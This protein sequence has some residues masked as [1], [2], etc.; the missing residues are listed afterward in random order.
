ML[1]DRFLG[2]S[3][4]HPRLRVV[5]VGA[6]VLLASVLYG[7]LNVIRLITLIAC[8]LGSPPGV[9]MEVSCIQQH[10][11]AE[12][13]IHHHLV[14]ATSFTK[15]LLLLGSDEVQAAH[16]DELLLARD[17]VGPALALDKVQGRLVVLLEVGEQVAHV[18]DVNVLVVAALAA[19]AVEG[20]VELGGEAEGAA[21]LEVFA[22]ADESE[23]RVELKVGPAAAAA[24]ALV[25]RH[26]CL[27]VLRAAQ[28]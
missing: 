15:P 8:D 27:A 12:A 28:T 16:E 20:L 4:Q 17:D 22:L 23:D 21:L 25:G 6:A 14:T 3:G 2:I 1:L 26:I 9:H 24:L 5:R 11:V 13:S 10:L 19:A 7:V 18:V